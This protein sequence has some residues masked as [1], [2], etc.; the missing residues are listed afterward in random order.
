M[1]CCAFAVFLLGQIALAFDGVRTFLFGAQ[2][3]T[4]T[5]PNAAVCWRPGMTAAAQASRFRFI[6]SPK[7]M[8]AAAGVELAVMAGG[9]IGWSAYAGQSPSLDFAMTY[10][11]RGGQI[12]PL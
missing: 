3:E 9:L 4:Q 8:A 12:A 10:I 7:I 11:C 6:A 5:K 1:A 2:D